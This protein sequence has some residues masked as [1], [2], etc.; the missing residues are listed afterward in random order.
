MPETGIALVIF[1]LPLEWAHKTG[2]ETPTLKTEVKGIH[3]LHFESK[4]S[5]VVEEHRR[6]FC[7]NEI[8]SL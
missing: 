3:N 7:H 6:L 1:N 8:N 2:L 5:P 4:I